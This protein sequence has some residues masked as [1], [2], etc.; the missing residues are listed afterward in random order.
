MEQD[1]EKRLLSEHIQHFNIPI[2]LFAQEKQRANRLIRPSE[3]TPYDGALFS[4]SLPE[5]SRKICII[6]THIK[7]AMAT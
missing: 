4:V 3:K 6:G 7:V 2:F 1:T 5:F